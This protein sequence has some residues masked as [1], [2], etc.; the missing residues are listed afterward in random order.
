MNLE[1]Y[2]K[3]ILIVSYSYSGN[4]HK[5]AQAINHITGGDFCD[6]Y[7]WQP[8][9]MSFPELL[10]QVRKEI[11][12]K[13]RPRLLPLSYSPQRYDTIFVGSPNWCGTIAPP[14]FA[15]L[16]GNDLSGKN[17]F[18]FC[19][20]CGGVPGNMQKDVQRI[21]KKSDV[22][23]CLSVINDGGEKI[24]NLVIQYLA[25]NSNFIGERCLSERKRK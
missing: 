5:I 15:W 20:H 12:A 11:T 13:Y 24:E 18:P 3:K 7:P 4:T 22:H 9:P 14:L 1:K 2:E 16:M 10:K 8:Y 23:K 19:S 21:C 17:I 25:E 6:I